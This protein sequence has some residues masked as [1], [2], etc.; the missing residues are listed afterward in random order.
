MIPAA[1]TILHDEPPPPCAGCRNLAEARRTPMGRDTA[2][3]SLFW[4]VL[5]VTPFTRCS[6]YEKPPAGNPS[7]LSSLMTR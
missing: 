4:C 6:L 3:R 7:H 5:H 1:T 2:P